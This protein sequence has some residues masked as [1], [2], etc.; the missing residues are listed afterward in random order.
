MKTKKLFLILSFLFFSIQSYSQGFQITPPKLDFDG[1]Q[2]TISYD[3]VDSR[4]ADQFYVWV[5]MEKKNGELI[6]S[7]TVTGDVGDKIKAGNNKKIAW[8][9]ENDSIF[10][11]E[12]VSVEVK[13]EKYI[14]SFN[15]GSMMLLST[16]IP[17]LGQ[18]KISKGRPWWLT[19]VATYGILA[20]GIIEYSKYL[21]TYDTYRTEEDPLKRSDL[22][23]KTQKQMNISKVLIVSGVTLWAANIFWVALTPNKYKPLQHVKLSVDH[24]AV[25]LKGTT[26][27]TLRLNF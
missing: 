27:L 10:L 9:P 16:A 19:G 2:L 21:K 6:K 5:E 3:F 11:N 20:G 12:M 18:A 7:K 25:P 22:F 13:A 8:V 17:G 23:N 14:K 4:K 15:K 26:L 1:R 24:S